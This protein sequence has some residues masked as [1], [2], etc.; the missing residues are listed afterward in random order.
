MFGDKDVGKMITLENA[1][2]ITKD[3]I[4]ILD[5]LTFSIPKGECVVICG[6]SGSG[7]STL[8][9]VLNGLYPELYEGE[10]LGTW[11]V[12]DQ[13]L[14]VTD[15]AAYIE[16][17]GVVFQNPKTHFFTTDVISELAFIMENFGYPSAE[18]NMRV[19]QQAAEFFLDS[20]LEASVFALSGGQKQQV[21]IAAATMLAPDLLLLDEPSSNLDFAAIA[22]L[23]QALCQLKAQGVTILIAEHRLAYLLDIADHFFV[24][25]N[26]HLKV[27]L[28]RAQIVQLTDAQRIELGLRELQASKQSLVH[29]LGIPSSITITLDRISYRYRKQT[30]VALSIPKLTLTNQEI[31]GI[32][33]DNGAGKSTFFQVLSGL[34]RPKKGKIFMNDQVAKEK[35]RID[36]CFFVM[37]DVNLQ[38]FFETVRK[39]LLEKA[40]LPERF[41]EICTR[42]NLTALLD[43]HPHTLSGGEK[44]R[45]VIASAILSGKTILLFDEPTSGL[46]YANM[47][48]VSTLLRELALEGVMVL[49]ISHDQ[50]FLNQTCHRLLHFEQGQIAADRRME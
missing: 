3:H 37:Q 4:Q 12:L 9:N 11:S 23:K 46:D 34:M 42:F 39:E 38:L 19:H 31:I 27:A 10:V 44:Q 16:R 18:I 26:G 29:K 48:Q 1:S 35:M 50:E 13:V 25:E 7:K 5:R 6:P 15:F 47:M 40:K 33:G 8:F 21:S 45:V 24:L 30:Q 22:R 20:I 32:T 14:P 36:A 17:F 28:T 43:R 2:F 49:V 41:D